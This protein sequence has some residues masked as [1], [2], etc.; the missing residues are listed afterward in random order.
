MKISQ[1]DAEKVIIV[2]AGHYCKPDLPGCTYWLSNLWFYCLAAVST[3]EGKL[4]FIK[5][6]AN[7]LRKKDDIQPKDLEK[8]I[9]QQPIVVEEKHLNTVVDG[10]VAGTNVELVESAIG[11]IGGQSGGLIVGM[12]TGAPSQPALSERLVI[13][14]SQ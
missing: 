7:R 12:C 10:A 11:V 6:N 1:Q 2:P 8:P 14:P 3:Q 13:K 4:A 9:E 5:A